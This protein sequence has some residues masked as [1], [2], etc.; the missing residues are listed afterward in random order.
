MARREQYQQGEDAGKIIEFILAR[1][2]AYNQ[3]NVTQRWKDACDSILCGLDQKFTPE[4][5]DLTRAKFFLSSLIN[6]DDAMNE[7]YADAYGMAEK[8]LVF[9]TKRRGTMELAER[10]EWLMANVYEEAEALNSFLSVLKD[11]G[12]YGMGVS[13]QRWDLR[14]GAAIGVKKLKG[15]WGALATVAMQNKTLWDRPFAERIHPFDW[16]GYWRQSDDLPW[17]GVMREWG[18]AHLKEMLE[19]EDGE[20]EEEGIKN[21]LERLKKGGGPK[22]EYYHGS[23]TDDG[24]D[25]PGA[26]TLQGYEYFGDLYGC[27]GHEKDCKEYQVIITDC[28][29]LKKVPNEIEGYRPIKRPRGRKLNDW[30]GGRPL[31]LPQV[32]ALKMQNFFANSMIDDVADRLYA[33]WAMWEDALESPDEFLNPQGIG[34]PV[35]MKKNTPQS[36]VPVRLGGNQSG[37][38]QDVA[39]IYKTVIEA[40]RQAGNFQDVLSQKG[41]IQ[42]GTARAANLIASQGARKMKAIMITANDTGLVPIAEQLLLL[43]FIHTDPR[44][45]AKQTRDG[46]PFELSD[47]ELGLLLERNLWSFSDSFRRD[48]FLDTDRMERFA[49]AGAVEFMG[50]NA[51]DPM[52]TAEFWREYARTLNIRNYDRYIP[53]EM[54]KP[55][56]P[57]QG[58]PDQGMPPQAAGMPPGAPPQ[59]QT[60][61]EPEAAQETPEAA[62]VS[63]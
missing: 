55:R 17:E 9:N 58:M 25:I 26:T 15:P 20:Y 6:A 19:D 5:E 21:A 23:E 27:P 53:L 4:E 13:Y 50:K 3:A 49:K 42:D 34:V 43:K 57:P 40:D 45:L 24:E 32:P 30:C 28:E 2:D 38:Q 11:L 16:F 1:K 63:A 41:G 44:D 59:A 52:I 51:A 33:G 54:P 46:K 12:P 60:P 47:D 62:A 7:V 56:M 36:Q 35:R 8:L 37:I 10:A 29:L 22:D 61:P 31:L 48:P 39:M 14:R 18:A